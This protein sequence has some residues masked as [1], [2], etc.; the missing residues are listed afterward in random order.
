MKATLP[1][2]IRSLQKEVDLSAFES[3]TIPDS[4]QK[5]RSWRERATNSPFNDDNRRQYDDRRNSDNRRN[6]DNPRQND[7]RRDHDYHRD[8]Q[9]RQ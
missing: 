6:D 7:G 1:L 2:L 4:N 5:A 3:D 8:L 9:V